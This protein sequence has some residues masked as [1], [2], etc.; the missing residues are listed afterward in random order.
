MRILT[1]NQSKK[2]TALLYTLSHA[3]YW[4]ALAALSGFTAVYLKSKGVSDSSTGAVVSV[5]AVAA[6]LIQLAISDYLDKNPS[7]LAKKL[8]VF[9]CAVS[10][11]MAILM[12]FI[13]EPIL[14][15]IFYIISLSALRSVSPLLSTLSVT[16]ELHISF[17]VPRGIGGAAYAVISLIAGFLIKKFSGD[18]IMI[19]Y[20]PLCIML[21]LSMAFMEEVH[22]NAPAESTVSSIGYIDILRKNKTLTLFLIA[23]ILNGAAQSASSTFLIRIIEDCGGSSGELGIT[24]FIQSISGIPMT[25]LMAKIRKKFSADKLVLFSFFAFIFRISLLAFV[26]SIPAIYFT[27]LLNAFCIGI[28]CVSSVDFADEASKADEKARAQALL[29]LSSNSGI[30]QILG[31]AFSGL[32]IGLVGARAMFLICGILCA[33]SFI[34]MIFCSRS[35][36]KTKIG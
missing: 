33:L 27:M 20:L 30:G 10:S 28:F 29:S 25:F 5:T 13:P 3:F 18:M 36:S 34:V 16:S 24:L 11:L 35:F 26:R 14:I 6:I 1:K 4:A 2:I 31:G 9:L 15:M 17:A 8:I 22:K 21:G 23:C 12:L 19:V 32:V 7:F